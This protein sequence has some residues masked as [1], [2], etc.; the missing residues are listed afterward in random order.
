MPAMAVIGELS[1]QAVDDGVIRRARWPGEDMKAGN[2]ISSRRHYEQQAA[3]ANACSR[4]AD[5]LQASPDAARKPG[6]R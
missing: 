2:Y 3:R 4:P 6:C 5:R 1:G